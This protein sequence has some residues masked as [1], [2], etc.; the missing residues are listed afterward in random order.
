MKVMNIISYYFDRR[1]GKK[2]VSKFDW[3]N[4]LKQQWTSFREV[5]GYDLQLYDSKAT[6]ILIILT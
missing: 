1:Q 3:K 5:G 6:L 4:D 2:P